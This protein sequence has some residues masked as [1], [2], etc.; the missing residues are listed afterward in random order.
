MVKTKKKIDEKVEAMDDEVEDSDDKKEEEYGKIEL[1][2]WNDDEFDG[3][4]GF[5]KKNKSINVIKKDLK[6]RLD[7]Y[8]DAW[9]MAGIPVWMYVIF[10]LFNIFYRVC[11]R[12]E[13]VEWW[14]VPA[15]LFLMSFIIWCILCYKRPSIRR[16]YNQLNAWTIIVKETEITEFRW[17]NRK[18]L[19]FITSNDRRLHYTWYRV[20][21]SSNGED[22]YKSSCYSAPLPYYGS[23]SATRS[24]KSKTER[25]E[26]EW[27]DYVVI[28]HRKYH[29]YDEVL[30]LIDHHNY[31]N[32]YL[33]L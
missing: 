31:K 6:K 28:G 10:L 1:N 19:R 11:S 32:Y 8:K 21:V 18:F 33:W 12:E 17:Y 26:I 20:I 29:I 25:K 16:I 27:I 9:F 13:L 2:D 5:I 30:V 23:F 24:R 7:G 22:E 15:G 4:P 3:E 14:M